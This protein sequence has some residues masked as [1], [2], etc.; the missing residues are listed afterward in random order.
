MGRGVGL[1]VMNQHISI[2]YQQNLSISRRSAQY[3]LY[4]TN[5][6]SVLPKK[7]NLILK[8]EIYLWHWHKDLRLFYESVNRYRDNLDQPFDST[9]TE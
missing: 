6:L 2:I 5:L 9:G 8:P 1:E 3:V 4:A 7:K